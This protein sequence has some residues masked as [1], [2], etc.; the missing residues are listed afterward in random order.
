MNNRFSFLVSITIV[1]LF[2]INSYSQTFIFPKIGFGQI[3]L[4]NWDVNAPDSYRLHVKIDEHKH[5]FLFLG[6]GIEH[7]IREN[8]EL[9]FSSSYSSKINY[10][11]TANGSWA[12]SEQ[13]TQYHLLMND[14]SIYYEILKN[15]SLG[16]GINSLYIRNF[17]FP[18]EELSDFRKELESQ[19]YNYWGYHFGINYEWKSLGFL[20]QYSRTKISK[21]DLSKDYFYP[22]KKIPLLTFSVL[23]KIKLGKIKRK[24]K[25]GCPT[26]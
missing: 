21:K 13:K 11:E 9:I 5:K 18:E 6:A 4:N 19:K 1:C 25:E 23:Y 15:I 14:I 7:K 3:N 20:L 17:K 22:V 8:L 12:N 16:G 2:S 10:I 26:F 24:R